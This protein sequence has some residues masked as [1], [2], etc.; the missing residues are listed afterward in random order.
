M[1]LGTSS[2]GFAAEV[3][4]EEAVATLDYLEDLYRDWNDGA[5]SGGGAAGR[6]DAEFARIRRELGY[7]PGL[8][9]DEP[10]LR[11]MLKHLTKTLHPGVLNDC[12]F[13]AA[14]AVC[15]RRAKPLGRPTPRH[16][17][18]LRCPNARRSLVHLPRLTTARDQAAAFHAARRADG[19][20]MPALQEQAIANYVAE[21]D[22]AIAEIQEPA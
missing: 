22:Q 17:M 5:R 10:R 20:G 9:T 21:L 16:N 2:S 12:F 4:A 14:T 6:I 13:H 1:P 19:A 3:A 7:L 15:V 18:C 11:T 8:V